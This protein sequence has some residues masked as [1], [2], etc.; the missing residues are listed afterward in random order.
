M[1]QE[2]S[3][4]KE[5]EAPLTEI[6]ASLSLLAG[7]AIDAEGHSDAEF[8]R[9]RGRQVQERVFAL[10][11]DLGLTPETAVLVASCALALARLLLAKEEGP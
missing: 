3:R 9:G 5:F 1:T 8:T 11:E 7:V 4:L 2:V 10:A 6:E